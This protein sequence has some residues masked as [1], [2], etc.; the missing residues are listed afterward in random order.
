MPSPHKIPTF[1]PLSPST[2]IYIP[3]TTT[4]K[5][6]TKPSTITPPPHL[7][8]L[9][10]YLNASPAHII[11]YVT[12]YKRKF[13]TSRI[14]LVTTSSS[15]FLVQS[16]AQWTREFEPAVGSQARGSE[17][18]WWWWWFWGKVK[19]LAIVAG[20]RV[21]FAVWFLLERLMG[22]ENVVGVVRRL[23]DPAQFSADLT[24]LYIYSGKDELVRAQEVEDHAEET[25]RKGYEVLRLRCLDS[26][27]AGHLL[28]DEE[29]FWRSVPGLWGS[30]IL[31]SPGMVVCAW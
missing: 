23:N 17:G 3:A 26:G 27:H 28:Q 4:A 15:H 22:V 7:I 11:K 24:R 9:C 6:T 31:S 1:T 10:T 19:A 2:S 14:L 16:A 30:R 13:P 20:L 18:S 29:Q 12:G 21:Y 8:L 25:E 5:T